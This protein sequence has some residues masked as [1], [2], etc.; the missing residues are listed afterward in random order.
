MDVFLQH[1]I[2]SVL[3][4]LGRETILMSE[5]QQLCYRLVVE[6]VCRVGGVEAL[7]ETVLWTR[8]LFLH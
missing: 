3:D 8:H 7:V 4:G 5:T 1:A 2:L 6:K